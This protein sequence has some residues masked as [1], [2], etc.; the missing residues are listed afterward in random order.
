MH[1]PKILVLTARVRQILLGL[2]YLHANRII[3]RDIKVRACA[4]VRTHHAR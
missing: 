4:R 1:L 3:H 2:Q